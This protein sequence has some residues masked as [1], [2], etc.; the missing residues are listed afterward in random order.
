MSPSAA[1]SV[2]PQYFAGISAPEQ[3]AAVQLPDGA[4]SSMGAA[5]HTDSKQ[6]MSVTKL[7]KTALRSLWGQ[8]FLVLALFWVPA[9]LA[10]VHPVPLDPK[11]DPATCL[12]CHGDKAKGKSV[13]TAVSTGCTSCHEIR[14]NKDV[15]RVKLITATPAALC[16]TCHADKNPAELKGLIHKPAVRDCLKCHDPHTSDNPNQLLKPLSGGEKENLCLGCHAIG[17]HTPEKGSR[18]AALD[19]GCDTCHLVH[20]TGASSDREF[21]RHLKKS[22]P[23]LC[24]ECHDP[25]DAD[26]AKAHQG[27]PFA[28]ADCVTCHNPHESAHPKLLQAFLHPPFEEKQC[29]VCHAPAQ[30]GKVV[31]TQASS[32]EL[33]V[34]CHDEKAKAIESAKVPHPGAAGDCVDCHNPHASRQPGLPKTNSVEICLACHTEQDEEMKTK[35]VLHQPAFQTGCATCHEPHGGENQHLLRAKEIN[36]LCLECHGPEA[37]QPAALPEQHLIS[38][39]EGKVRLPEDYFKK[40]PILPLRYGTGHPVEGHPVSNTLN[41]KTNKPVAINCLTCHQPH[42]SAKPGLLVKDQEANMAFCK[43]CHTEGTLQLK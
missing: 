14:V 32:K 37:P 43:T 30:D 38:I 3:R 5:Y 17:V 33:C 23:A 41:T 29:E 24:L 16:F 6:R 21:T 11:A 27:Q 19:A 12:E 25:K 18:H 13:H 1:M 20:K 28:T 4:Q 22:T 15:T 42:A 40:V 26:L 39:F 9:A 34:T 8:T 2:A 10:D 31:L 36:P 35:R 7:R